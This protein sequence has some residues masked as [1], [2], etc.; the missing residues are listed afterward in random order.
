MHHNDSA[1]AS[2]SV[3]VQNSNTSNSKK[4]ITDKEKDTTMITEIKDGDSHFNAN[5]IPLSINQRLA[6]LKEKTLAAS[7]HVTVVHIFYGHDVDQS[8]Q[9]TVGILR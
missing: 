3:L 6:S 9:S 2:S 4:E 1:F 8:P 5:S 7:S